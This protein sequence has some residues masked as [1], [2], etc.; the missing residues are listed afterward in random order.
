MDSPCM[1]IDA[2]PRVN[3]QASLP[4]GGVRGE[5]FDG[6]TRRNHI[7]IGAPRWT[8]GAQVRGGSPGSSPPS[9]P[10]FEKVGMK[11]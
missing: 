2:S 5:T 10:A 11:R 6:W 8:G 4:V 1:S 3:I 7:G 9:Q